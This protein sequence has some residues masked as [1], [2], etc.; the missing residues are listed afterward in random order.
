ME[1]EQI[2]ARRNSIRQSAEFIALSSSAKSLKQKRRLAALKMELKALDD[3][4]AEL[5]RQTAAPV[6]EP[7]ARGVMRPRRSASLATRTE[8]V[9]RLS[10]T[11]AKPEKKISATSAARRAALLKAQ[12]EKEAA[13]KAEEARKAEE[14]L[15][16]ALKA[17]EARKAEEALKEALKAEEARKDE[18]KLT[19]DDE[20]DL[21]M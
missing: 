8:P 2:N 3:R 10:T 5:S 1:L 9:V 4:A 21:A 6:P 17:E 20:L 7:R 15:K 13:L 12:K 16:E 14:A 18:A 19:I 11:P